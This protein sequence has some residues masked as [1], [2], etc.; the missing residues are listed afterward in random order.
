MPSTSAG[1]TPSTQDATAARSPS[2][3]ARIRTPFTTKTRHIGDFFV[4]PDDPHRQYG[5]GDVITGSV[6]LKVLK[7][8][9]VTHI[10]VCLHGFVQVY[11]AA[12]TPGEGYKAYTGTSTPGKTMRTGYFGNG[13]ASLFV[14]EVALCG[15]GRLGE[16]TYQFGY[17]LVFPKTSQP[18]SINVRR[19]SLIADYSLMVSQF[20]RGT[21]A[22]MITCT[23]TKPTTIAPVV[24]RD[25]EIRYGQDINIA[26][27]PRPKPRVIT[28]E[29]LAKR[30]RTRRHQ[31][32]RTNT[33][34]TTAE[35]DQHSSG[36][37]TGSD[38]TVTQ[39][40]SITTSSQPDR[41][42]VTSPAPSEPSETSTESG[43][44]NSGAGSAVG[45]TTQ[46]RRSNG[47]SRA[48][49][50][51]GDQRPIST[52]IQL[53]EG[54][55]LRGDTIQIRISIQ[56]RK[57]VRSLHG[58]ILTFYRQARVD[59]HPQLPIIDREGKLQKGEDYYPKS[60]T[61]LGGLSLSAAGSSH[62]FRKD[63]AQSF[64]SLIVNPENL[65]AD[66]K[67]AVRIPEEAFPT[68][69][70]V[71]GNMISFK[72]YVEVIL[73]IQG[74][75]T[76]LSRLFA[77]TGN[78]YGSGGGL[79]GAD[80]NAGMMSAW[81]GHFIDT[82]DLRRE[83]SVISSL[84]EVVVGTRDSARLQGVPARA[85]PAESSVGAVDARSN[86]NA[87]TGPQPGIYPGEA[88]MPYDYDAQAHYDEGWGYNGYEYD[89]SV[90]DGTYDQY[91]DAMYGQ[92][93]P[94]MPSVPL[95]DLAEENEL[96]EKERLR[97]AEARLLPSQPP[98][99][100]EPESSAAADRFAPSAPAL[101]DSH[102]SSSR[103]VPTEAVPSA[104]DITTGPSGESSAAPSYSGPSH[105]SHAATDDKQE[106]QRRRLQLE[107]SAPEEDPTDGEAAGPSA[108]PGALAAEDEMTPTAPV[109]PDPSDVHDDGDDH[110]V[111]GSFAQLPKYE[112]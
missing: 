36:S 93:P 86:L 55:Y 74:K 43:V 87:P 103:I 67:A 11:K 82:Q 30:G 54:G 77:N 99:A 40:G 98:D 106:L 49:S 79:P 61:G 109:L 6:I 13:F 85:F 108:P 92:A 96:P 78:Q 83:K 46:S 48:A 23:L 69:S 75:L 104:G 35:A 7:P 111:G 91:Y 59:M 50:Q 42:A 8:V 63:L 57:V 5:P 25:R 64:A 100:D 4:Q 52:S 16:G 81:G 70:G 33:T 84:F 21:I 97:R 9:R 112:R 60:K 41:E 105:P 58:V 26:T 89:P 44:S 62:V 32:R 110:E 53:A 27:I 101:D 15:E 28:L 45:S 94:P 65:T 88:P 56:H 90:G 24:I 34:D 19:L 68:I 1:T 31:L 72:Y 20:E 12:N 71:P 2:L 95:P 38:G 73:D 66:I 80:A 14:D 102:A 39:Q 29:P 76:G 22:Y 107:R 51:Q 18:S 47:S 3:L 37:M 10:T 17:E